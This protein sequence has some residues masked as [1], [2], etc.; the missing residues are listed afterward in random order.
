MIT[1]WI[2]GEF[3]AEY[4]A[5]MAW[6]AYEAAQTFAQQNPG[7][8]VRVREEGVDSQSYWY[9]PVEGLDRRS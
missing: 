8:L 2:G 5:G 9:D 7:E 1:V 4:P 3:A 6:L